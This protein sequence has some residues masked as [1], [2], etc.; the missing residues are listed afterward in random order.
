MKKN[1]KNILILS[2][3]LVLTLALTACAQNKIVP[4]ELIAVPIEEQHTDEAGTLLMESSVDTVEFTGGGNGA[5]A[6]MTKTY[7]DIFS[8]RAQQYIADETGRTAE[9]FAESGQTEPNSFYT[10]AAGVMR[11]DE[12]LFVLSVTTES[13]SAGAAH[14]GF[15]REAVCFDPNDGRALTL[16]DLTADGSDPT[17]QLSALL[18]DKYLLSEYAEGGGFD[19]AEAAE[20]ITYMLADGIYQWYITD[21]FVLICNA[22]DLASYSMGGFELTLT[23]EELNGIVKAEW[24]AE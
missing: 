11:S 7:A 13:L 3:V 20:V 8:L 10:L 14:G 5:A 15:I 2:A 1:I 12:R 21:S 16:K 9:F 24:F 23:P 6:A 19:A 17:A 4:V 18:A 22:Y